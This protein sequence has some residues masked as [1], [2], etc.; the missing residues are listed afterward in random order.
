MHQWPFVAR[1]QV[2]E[3]T[4]RGA[5]RTESQRGR[6]PGH[7]RVLQRRG[8]GRT[9]ARSAY[10]RRQ[11]RAQAGLA[12]ARVE[13]RTRRAEDDVLRGAGAD[14]HAD[15]RH[16]GQLGGEHGGELARLVHDHVRPPAPAGGQ[17]PGQ[18]HPC[19]HS[20][21]HLSNDARVDVALGL[22]PRGGEQVVALR[23][24]RP[25]QLDHAE[26]RDPRRGGAGAAGRDEHVTAR[27]GHGGYEGQ[28]RADVTCSARRC[29][30][31]TDHV[32]NLSLRPRGGRARPR[33]EP[34]AWH[35][36]PAAGRADGAGPNR[37]AP[38]CQGRGCDHKSPWDNAE[39]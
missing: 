19:V 12:T 28:Q 8:G 38:R 27:A 23:R 16:A 5:R 20:R 37:A 29:H 21:E 9:S 15:P 33:A 11:D 39:R 25:A 1:P 2:G 31:H 17:H 34:D 32:W 22:T 36:S 30:Q 6:R 26:A 14:R 4:D 7:R 18:R 35:V 13:C 10:R 24:R 3:S